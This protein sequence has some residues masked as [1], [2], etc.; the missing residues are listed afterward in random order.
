MKFKI[1]TIT[2]HHHYINIGILATL[3]NDVNGV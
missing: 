3:H 2:K 1:D